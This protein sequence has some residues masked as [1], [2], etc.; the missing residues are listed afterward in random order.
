MRLLTFFLF[1]FLLS[2]ICLSQNINLDSYIDSYPD[3]EHIVLKNKVKISYFYDKVKKKYRAKSSHNVKL[4]ALRDNADALQLIQIPF[5]EYT[6]V[7][8]NSARYFQLDTV[9]A[10]RLKEN[11]KVR[12]AEEKDYYIN[13]IFYSNLKVKQFGPTVAVDEGTVLQYS[14]DVYYNDLKFLTSFYTQS[15]AYEPV[16]NYEIQLYSPK[17]IDCE[18]L[19]INIEG[20]DFK[21]DT[22]SSGTIKYSC[23]KVK[24]KELSRY[25]PPRAYHVPHFIVLTKTIKKGKQTI[26]FISTSNDL[27]NWYKELV[28]SVNND[29]EII[30]EYSQQILNGSEN[31]EQKIEKIFKWVQAKINYVAFEDGIAGFRP[32]N[33]QNV[34][35]NR[36]GDCKGMANLLVSLLKQNQLDAHHAWIGT[37]HIPYTYSIP[38]LVVDN[39][40]ICALNHNSKWYYLDATSKTINWDWPSKGIQGKEVLIDNGGSVLINRVPI[41]PADQNE[42]ILDARINLNDPRESTIVGN[43]SFSGYHEHRFKGVHNTT[44]NKSKDKVFEYVMSD[45]LGGISYNADKQ[46]IYSNSQ[47]FSGKVRGHCAVSPNKIYFKPSFLNN[48]LFPHEN[49][50]CNSSVSFS[51]T[52]SYEMTFR[53][54]GLPGL[55]NQTLPAPIELRMPN[56]ECAFKLQYTSDG[57]DILLNVHLEINSLLIKKDG[58][59]QWIEFLKSAQTAIDQPIIVNK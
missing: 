28:N 5:N 24:T 10:L 12:Y 21:K 26:P 45:V 33:A 13:G 50:D 55:G 43:V 31:D 7:K 44:S 15:S 48:L 37:Q 23:N 56:N 35:L 2:H 9:G 34:I 57:S 30:K 25:A 41:I 19:P 20:Y 27:F 32:D 59:K 14:Y 58:A 36:Y 51:N 11:V 46:V 39:H 52:S 3:F 53:L 8:I 38:S 16:E 18:L 22:P 42:M 29:E 54:I 40:M 1:S 47:K 17:E 49:L 4:L 6:E